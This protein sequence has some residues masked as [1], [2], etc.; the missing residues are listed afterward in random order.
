MR[1]FSERWNLT[2]AQRGVWHA[3][4]LDPRGGARFNVGGHVEIHGPVDEDRFEEAL[5]RVVGECDALH[6]RF[7]ESNGTPRQYLAPLAAWPY[8]RADVSAEPN[9]LA[10]AEAWTRADMGRAADLTEG[11]LFAFALFKAAD[12]HY[13]WY[14]RAHHIIADAFSFSAITARVAEVYTALRTGGTYA[15]GALGSVRTLVALDE[16]YRTSA[17]LVRD[18]A[19]WRETLAG[20]PEPVALGERPPGDLVR[21]VEELGEA[22]ARELRRRARGFGTGTAGLLVAAFAAYAHRVTGAEE[23]TLG[24][25]VTGRVRRARGPIPGMMSN[26]LPVRVGFAG[27]RPLDDL[28]R[29]TSHALREG[30]RHQ[31]YRAE[32]MRRDLGLSAGHGL[33]G[34]LVNVIPFGAGPRFDGMRCTVR[35]LPC[36]AFDD[37]CVSCYDRPGD[38]SLTIAFD[39]EGAGHAAGFT[40]FLGSL[41]RSGPYTPVGAIDL[42]SAGERRLM[43]ALGSGGARPGW[44]PLP[45]LFEE[46]VRRTPER[47][48]LVFENTAVTY[49]ELNE[50][51]NRLARLLIGMGAGPEKT[52][53]VTLPRSERLAVAI[54]AIVKTGAACL[55]V[56]PDDPDGR[57]NRLLADAAPVCV[58]TTDPAEEDETESGFS[59]AD[60]S[61]DERLAPPHPEHPV[62][63]MYTSGSTGHPKGVVLPARAM[64]NLLARHDSAFPVDGRSV[65][66]QCSGLG[67]DVSAQEIFSALWSGKTLAIPS[68]DVRRDPA[69][70]AR[71]LDRYG[72]TELFAPAPVLEA[73]IEAARGLLLPKLRHVIQTGEILTVRG[74][75]RDF[76]A[77]VPERRLHNDHGPT[78]THAVTSLTL[79]GE[80]AE[81]PELPSIGRPVPGT[82]VYVLDDRLRPV[83]AGVTG[84]LYVAGA[85]LA[86]CYLGLRG[87]TAESFVADPYGPDGTRMY[88]TGDLVQWNPDGTLRYVGREDSQVKIRGLRVEPAEVEAALATHP[89]VGQVAVTAREDLPG[90]RRLVAYV[91][92]SAPSDPAAL[93]AHAAGLLP[94]HLAPS[95][96]VRLDALPLTRDG[97]LDHAALPAPPSRGRA[98]TMA[99]VEILCGLYADVLGLPRVGAYDDFFELGGHSLLAARL[100]H[101]IRATL[102]VRLPIR[103]VFDSP[104]AADL[105]RR[106]ETAPV[107]EPH[108]PLSWSQERLWFRRRTEPTGAS[109]ASRLTGP[110]NVPALREALR[111][112]IARHEALRTV[113]PEY[114]GVRYQRVLTADAFGLP[115]IRSTRK[116]LARLMNL[117]DAVHFDPGRDLPVRAALFAV[118]EDE[119]VLFCKIYH[120]AAD[121]PSMMVLNRDLAT[122]YSALLA[123]RT[124]EWKPL[125]FQYADFAVWQH[126]KLG[127]PNDP[128]S[129][130]ARQSACWRETLAGL[131]GEATVQPDRPRPPRPT[132]ESGRVPFEIPSDLHER[133]FDVASTTGTS[134]FMVLQAALAASMTG[135]GAGTDVPIGTP[136]S[137]REAPGLNDLIGFFTN[138]VVLRTDTSGDPNLLELLHRI[139]GTNTTARANQDVPFELLAEELASEGRAHPLFQV[140]LNPD[141]TARLRLPGVTTETRPGTAPPFAYDLIL[142]YRERDSVRRHRLR[143]PLRERSVRR[144]HR[145]NPVGTPDRP[146]ERHPHRPNGPDL[147]H[148]PDRRVVLTPTRSTTQPGQPPIWPGVRGLAGSAGGSDSSKMPYEKPSAWIS[149]PD[150]V[151]PW[152][153]SSRLTLRSLGSVAGERRGLITTRIVSSRMYANG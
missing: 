87:P 46:R 36:A 22:Q 1:L 68:D 134:V 153:A 18:R 5:R 127:S 52:V 48:A 145:T 152:T 4:H 148:R 95:A 30:L 151:T 89:S 42:L 107:A 27:D 70:L 64:A 43:I 34:P 104:A 108:P 94:A 76:F 117:W 50:R 6:A 138:V 80:A 75:V 99:R 21:Q 106:L 63:V 55:L 121:D 109:L 132:Y 37:L 66:G 126:E 29:G 125:P 61:D 88:R 90:D 15:P 110:L 118:G 3:H 81:W 136:V 58:V 65:T 86:R 72:V 12:D 122:A 115:V 32:D 102:G 13:L 8:H 16:E 141:S 60:L 73:V 78:E 120:S 83:P 131:P 23:V 14:Q 82:R 67:S 93:R 112:V 24:V 74:H 105:A 59:S 135:A 35:P 40:R 57:V 10:A 49:R 31:R 142:D 51:A 71:W 9:P 140:M 111:A 116:T 53:A 56:D 20:L 149:S 100:V 113:L 77:R 137:G 2:A 97:E 17:D 147:P 47:A 44:T 38:E 133:A 79:S 150:T 119:H 25:P 84:E 98:S 92:P 45:A 128:G 144:E 123:G 85:Q 103:A 41:V 28:V 26:V 139:R 143:L 62:Y 19:Y 11:P 54:V 33:F 69:A 7:A 130:I 91:V 124:P 39:G 129:E 146:T 101:R 96:F 114:E